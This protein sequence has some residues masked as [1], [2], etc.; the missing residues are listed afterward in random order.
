MRKLLVKPGLQKNGQIVTTKDLQETRDNFNPDAQPPIT[1]GHPTSSESPAFGRVESVELTEEGLEGNLNY[2]PELTALESK[3]YYKGWSVGLKPGKNG[4][5]LHHLAMCGELPPA[6]EIKNLSMVAVEPTDIILTDNLEDTSMTPDEV[7]QLIA[8]ETKPYKDKITALEAQ[9]AA[10]KQKGEEK[11]GDGEKG[12]PADKDKAEEKPKTDK[13][14]DK[15]G[16]EKQSKELADVLGVLKKE[17]VERLKEA[18]KAKGLS[19]DQIKPLVTMV[20]SAK[21]ISL[22][23]ADNPFDQAMQFVAGLPAPDKKGMTAPIELSDKAG[24]P[25]DYNGLAAKM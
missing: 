25:F 1:L 2:T 13:A 3:G 17:R 18:A 10:S 5:Y 7:K 24:E 19:D 23:D 9:V 20:E 14:E 16:D 22:A 11:P 4:Y 8:E 6:G 12:K 21:D 15:K